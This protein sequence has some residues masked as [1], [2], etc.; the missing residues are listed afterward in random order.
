MTQQQRIQLEHVPRHDLPETFADSSTNITFDGQ[1]WRI[2]FCSTRMEQPIP[3][4][5]LRGKQ[6]TV[7]RLVLTPKAGFD[8]ASN[9]NTIVT[10]MEKQGVIKR[11]TQPIMPPVS[12]KPN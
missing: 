9:L 12:G 1:C 11:V 4:A 8:L 10:Q 2:E 7:C 6:V 3:P 5:T